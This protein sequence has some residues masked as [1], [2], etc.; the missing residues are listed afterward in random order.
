[1]PSP[2]KGCGQQTRVSSRKKSLRGKRLRIV[3]LKAPQEIWGGHFAS[4]PSLVNTRL[5]SRLG[6]DTLDQVMC[7][8][9]QG[10][11]RPSDDDQEEVALKTKP[12]QNFIFH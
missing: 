6:E 3:W 12:G 11:H 7:V 10:P 2:G 5:K 1:M 4:T 9:N 8:C